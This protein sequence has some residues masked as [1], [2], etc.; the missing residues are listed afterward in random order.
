MKSRLCFVGAGGHACANLYPAAIEAGWDIV[1]ISTRHIESAKNAAEKFCPNAILFT[2]VNKMLNEMEY[3]AVAV[4]AQPEA[5]AELV[6]QIIPSCPL[7]FAEKP[8]GI[9]AHQAEEIAQLATLH[10]TKGMVGFMKR[11]APSYKLVKQA[12]ESNTYGLP[13]SFQIQFCVHAGAFA[14]DHASFL[15]LAGIHLIDLVRYLFGEVTDIQAQLSNVDNGLTQSYSLRCGEIIG[16]LYFVSASSWTREDE[17]MIV[18]FENGFIETSNL[19]NVK[20][21]RAT[22]SSPFTEL[23]EIDQHYSVTHMPFSGTKRDLY[24]RGFVGE[25]MHLKDDKIINEFVDNAKTMQLV[26]KMLKTNQK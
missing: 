20:T 19:H 5:M 6:K 17:K 4:C 14:P 1:A 16:S 9:S 18:T 22:D 12:I 7:I 10:N 8:L 3:D 25:F 13:L 11:Y 2:D 24:L 21:H 26:E 15:N 23:A